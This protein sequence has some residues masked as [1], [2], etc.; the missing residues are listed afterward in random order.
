MDI[1]YM[2]EYIYHNM[3]ILQANISI[4]VINILS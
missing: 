3:L 2:H 4:I 1:C